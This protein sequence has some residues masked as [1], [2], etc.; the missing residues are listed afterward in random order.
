MR[1]SA[2][3]H[4][5]TTPADAR[6]GER[7]AQQPDARRVDVSRDE[8]AAAFAPDAMRANNVR[9]G[10]G[11][12]N[13]LFLRAAIPEIEANPGRLGEWRGTLLGLP[14]LERRPPV[15]DRQT[16]A[17]AITISEPVEGADMAGHGVW[18]RVPRPTAFS[19]VGSEHVSLGAMT[20]LTD[21]AVHREQ[22]RVPEV[23]IV[24][25]SLFCGQGGGDFN[26]AEHVVMLPSPR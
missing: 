12:V 7:L 1:A 19:S 5:R 11:L 23:Q 9:L 22:D 13:G 6:L 15:V 24:R 3:M 8:S 14:V 10:L 20:P 18:T 21:E 16:H 4:A 2:A 26:G 17:D 25:G